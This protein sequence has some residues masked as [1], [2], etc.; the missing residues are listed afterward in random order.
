MET[1]SEEPESHE[2]VL[3]PTRN[4]QSGTATV[5]PGNRAHSFRG[6]MDYLWQIETGCNIFFVLF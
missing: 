3:H 6:G 2:F 4:R 5:L 1:G